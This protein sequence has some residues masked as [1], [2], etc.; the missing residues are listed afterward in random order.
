MGSGAQEESASNVRGHRLGRLGGVSRLETIRGR[1]YTDSVSGTPVPI[2][3]PT[4]IGFEKWT[5]PSTRFLSHRTTTALSRAHAS[6]GRSK[7][8]RKKPRN[9]MF[10][11]TCN[12]CVSVEALRNHV[13]GSQHALSITTNSQHT[14]NISRDDYAQQTSQ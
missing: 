12:V 1:Q 3:A 14:R 9:K 4:L 13:L 10:W 8:P 5:P 6:T 2:R 7:M 11:K